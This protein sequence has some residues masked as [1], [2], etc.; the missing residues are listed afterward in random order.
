MTNSNLV[1]KADAAGNSLSVE[2]NQERL[3]H[4]FYMMHGEPTSR[5]KVFG[6]AIYVEKADIVQL[7]DCLIEK[8]QLAKVR[9][10]VIRVGVGF[11]KEITEKNYDEFKSYN[12][13]EPGK[14]KE[15]YIKINFLYEDFDSGNPLKHAF[16][17]RIARELNPGNIFQIIASSDNDK[18]D[19][20]ESL[21]SPVF[22]RTDHIN[23]DLSK[24]LINAVSEWHKGQKQPQLISASYKFAKEHKERLARLIHYIYPAVTCAIMCAA[25]FKANS[26][27]AGKPDLLPSL[28][29]ILIVA[30][31]SMNFFSAYGSRRASK[32]FD[33][34]KKISEEDVV[35]KI[36]KGDDKDYSERIDKNNKLFTSA[37]KEAIWVLI[38]NVAAGVTATA[39]YEFWK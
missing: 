14:T 25:M 7:I 17:L 8:L 24:S 30:I 18:L 20:F 28:F 21:L 31:F 33:H 23:D 39:V 29:T 1:P 27:M 35:F 22:C 5:T 16:F 3:K 32:I 12:W 34:L 38:H 4:F 6:G 15:L 2:I 13:S 19:N 36:T 10:Q 11:D 26:L 9:D 37:S